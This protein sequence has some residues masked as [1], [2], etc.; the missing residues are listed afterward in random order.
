[1]PTTEATKIAVLQE[2]H[3]QMVSDILE[4]KQTQKEQGIKLDNIVNLLN[5]NFVPIHEFESYKASN[6]KALILAKKSATMKLVVA[7]LVTAIITALVYS[8]FD[9]KINRGI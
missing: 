6:D 9:N 4:I 8:F 1:M 3:K 7:V 5:S 2:G